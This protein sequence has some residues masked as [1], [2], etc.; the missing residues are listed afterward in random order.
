MAAGS[1]T[2][3]IVLINQDGEEIGTTDVPIEVKDDELR[4]A[5]IEL[6]EAVRELSDLLQLIFE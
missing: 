3:R 1:V 4:S 6:H 5:V 2:A